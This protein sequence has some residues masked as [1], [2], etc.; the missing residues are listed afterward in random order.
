[1]MN[2]TLRH[3]LQKLE[4]RLK[5]VSK[6]IHHVIHFVAANGEVTCKLTFEN[7]QQ[8]WWYAPGHELE[9]RQ[10]SSGVLR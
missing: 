3:R 2:R 4:V 5:P 7:G 10:V 1:M 8:K 6:P 9:N